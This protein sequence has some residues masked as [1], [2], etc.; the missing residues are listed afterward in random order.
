MRVWAFAFFVV[1][2]GVALPS[3]AM[4]SF[5]RPSLPFGAVNQIHGAKGDFDF[6]FFSAFLL[7]GHDVSV[8]DAFSRWTRW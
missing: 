2:V 7:V 5:L 1:H 4:I 6:S 3:F 8:A